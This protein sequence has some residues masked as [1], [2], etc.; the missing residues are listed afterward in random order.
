MGSNCSE[1]FD[2]CQDHRCQ[3]NA[4]CLD[5]VNGYSCLCTEGYRYHQEHMGHLGGGDGYVSLCRRDKSWLPSLS[6]RSSICPAIYP[7]LLREEEGGWECVSLGGA[8]ITGEGP[9]GTAQKP[10]ILLMPVSGRASSGPQ[11]RAVL[12]ELYRAL[13]GV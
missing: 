12:S 2:D 9:Q 13:G 8:S 6:I 3:N 5:E 11:I 1:D 10:G 7:S 4:R